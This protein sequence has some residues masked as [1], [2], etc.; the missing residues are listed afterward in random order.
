MI[1][2]FNDIQFQH[3]EIYC[4]FNKSMFLDHFCLANLEALNLEFILKRESNKYALVPVIL[5]YQ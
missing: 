4:S 1:L 3:T 2:I 5:L